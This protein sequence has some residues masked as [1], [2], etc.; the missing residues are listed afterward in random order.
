MQNYSVTQAANITAFAGF[1]ILILNRFG[2]TI[3]Q[4]DLEL[5]I[6]ALLTAGG[7]IKNYSHRF[8]RGDL[9]VSGFRK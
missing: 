1:L 4:A 5:L 3:V 8:S 9:S 7:I 2:I 6:G